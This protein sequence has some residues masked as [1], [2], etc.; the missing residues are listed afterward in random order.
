MPKREYGEDGM[1]RLEEMVRASQQ[2]NINDAYDEWNMQRS[3]F[4]E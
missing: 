4:D 2:E 1:R 3:W